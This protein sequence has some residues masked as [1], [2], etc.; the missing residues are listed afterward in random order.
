[1]NNILPSTSTLKMKA[2][3]NITD[4]KGL[5]MAYIPQSHTA[6][7]ARPRRARLGLRHVFALW[8]QRRALA[9]MEDWQ[10]QD[11]GLSEHDIA[12]ESR[13]APWDAPETWRE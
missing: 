9:R 10:R 7:S 5:I 2:P 13:R 1:M 8:K 4:Q 3:E 12:V 6:C 11:L